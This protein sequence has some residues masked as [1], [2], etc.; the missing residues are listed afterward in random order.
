M[1]LTEL[2][3]D[4]A[5]AIREKS[6]EENKIKA[7]DFPLAIEN[8]KVVESDNILPL[9]YQ[10]VEYL[11]STGEQCI[12]S[13]V[14]PNETTRTIIDF[15]YTDNTTNTNLFG[16]RKA[17][18]TLGY[19]VG[20]DSDTLGKKFWIKRGTDYGETTKTS[21]KLR[22]TIDFSR[23]FIIDGTNLKTTYDNSSIAWKTIILFGS[24]ENESVWK[25]SYRLYSCKIYNQDLIIR[26]FKPCYRKSDNKTGLYDLV[27][28]K[29]YPNM[30]DE[31]EF[32]IGKKINSTLQD[33]VITKN[34]E[35][36][37]ADGYTG[38]GKIIVNI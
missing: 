16:T 19:Y 4:I 11:E 33:I 31:E 17:W 3:T 37:P 34:G 35:Y 8:I 27:D 12:D 2:F 21:D 18:N 20:T 6:G 1:Q 10:E 5:D 14:I 32:I 24:Y 7:Q 23:N 9:E 15:Q 26:D 36:I 25:S 22:H 38:F 28:K 13:D 29:F 30:S